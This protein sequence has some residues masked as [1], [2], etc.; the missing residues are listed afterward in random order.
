[1]EPDWLLFASRT[2]LLC[3]RLGDKGTVRINVGRLLRRF[4]CQMHTPRVMRVEAVTLCSPRCD[5]Q[6]C[7]R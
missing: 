4:R 1:M 6:R 7:S 5:A 2:E 3:R